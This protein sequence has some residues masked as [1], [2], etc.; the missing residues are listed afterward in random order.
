M[1]PSSEI[2]RVAVAGL[3][4]GSGKTLVSLG[5]SCALRRRGRPVIPFKKGPDYIDAAWHTLATGEPCRNLDT[6]MMGADRVCRS[7]LSSSRLGAISLVEGNRGVFDGMDACGTH[8]TAELVKL[9]RCPIILVVDCTKATRTTASA[10]LGCRVFDPDLHVAGVV[11]NRVAG[12][13]HEALARQAI[14]DY[15]DVPVLGAIRR[16]GETHVGERH[17]GLLPPAEHDDAGRALELV[18]RVVDESVDVDAVTAIADAADRLDSLGAL[19]SATPVTREEQPRIGVIRD[20]AFTFYYPENLEQLRAHGAELAEVDALNDPELP[21]LDALYIG[22]GFPETH[23][24]RLAANETFRRSVR[25][26][27][28]QGLPVYAECGGLTFLC[29]GIRVG[30]TVY[31]MVGVFPVTFEMAPSPQGH[32]YTVM[33]VD[34]PNPFFAVGTVVRGHEFRYSRA[35]TNLPEALATAYRVKR[36]TGFD[37]VRDGLCYR[38]VFASFCHIHAVGTEQWAPALVARALEF[39]RTAYRQT[40]LCYGAMA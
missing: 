30:Q 23:A 5:L 40:A 29:N 13:R 24:A 3:R 20:S 21:P 1:V 18:W 17:L 9:L 34:S 15:T 4:G 38:N 2:P 26:E 28:E 12:P 37:G 27:V 35:L 31:P 36:G 7:F 11:L 8:S 22:G 19:R 25:Y 14:E 39:H 6:F 16:L 10:V 32:G 33:E